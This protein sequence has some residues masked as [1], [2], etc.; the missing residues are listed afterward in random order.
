MN[1]MKEK[2]LH[3]IKRTIFVWTLLAGTFTMSISQSSL[4]TAYPTLMKYFGV[5]APTI[6]WLTTGFMLIMCVMMPLSPWLLNNY[7]FKKIY[8]SVLLIF[9]VGTIMI[10]LSPDFIFALIGRALEAIA[11]GVLFPSFQ[12]V[13]L[14][15]TPTKKRP[16]VMGL[17]GLVMGSALACG[18]IISGIILNY[19]SW[20]SLFCFFLIV[21]MIVFVSAV[22][23]IYDVLPRQKSCFD[24]ISVIA[25]FGLIG[26]LYVVQT[27]GS[28]LEMSSSL[29]LL[30]IIS[31]TFTGY[32][33][34]RQFTLDQP[35]L[36]L[37][38][39]RVVNFDLAVLL[40]GI[41]YIS[42]IVITV[43][44]PLYY[45]KILHTSVLVSG[46]ALVPP[47]FLLSVLNPLTGKLAEKIGFKKTL[48]IGMLM[49]VCGWGAL[50]L[51]AERLTLVSMIVF[52][53]LIEGGN[54]FVMM[55][56]TTLGAD[57]LTEAQ[58]S[59]GTAIITTVRQLLG[60][61]GVTLA[62]LI[63]VAGSRSVS[64]IGGYRHAF[65]FFCALEI[66]GFILACAIR[67]TKKN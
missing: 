19:L 14:T 27:Y 41:A 61:L 25:S 12:T 51:L 44:Y 26:I 37:S 29:L 53:M 21:I 64:S 60:A 24:F 58:I 39:M 7:S 17:A 38:V 3:G 35:L 34:Y 47:A 16:S 45:Q 10:I 2:E 42:L 62:T 56:A 8:L 54:A 67:Q 66:A 40:T 5:D 50:A 49:L 9:M 59:H 30:L 33:I 20:Q 18:P 63:V 57:S 28:K 23:N 1:Y 65:L 48:I 11:V 55:P 31:L 22:F 13:L 43:I 15:I 46:L 36:K 6:Q 4:S 52:A 32:F